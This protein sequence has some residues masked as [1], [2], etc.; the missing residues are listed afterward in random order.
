[1]EGTI[2]APLGARI[3]REIAGSQSL[4][5]H[6]TSTILM[7]TMMRTRAPLAERGNDL[8]ETPPVAV[9]ALLKPSH[10]HIG[11]GNRPAV[12]CDCA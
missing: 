5:A 1:M 8:Y 12:R 9:R 11:Y 10:C 6:L 7:G 3:F 2:I 4:P